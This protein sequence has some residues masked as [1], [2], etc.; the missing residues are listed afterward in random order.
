M[1][2]EALEMISLEGQKASLCLMRIHKK[3]AEFNLNLNDEDIK[4]RS[5]QARPTFAKAASSGHLLNNLQK[6]AGKLTATQTLYLRHMFQ[7]Y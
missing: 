7:R 5:M 3:L 1:V 2:G 6:T 4:D